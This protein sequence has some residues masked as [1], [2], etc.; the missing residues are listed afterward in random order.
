MSNL[1]LNMRHKC[2]NEE[3]FT[4]FSYSLKYF[5]MLSIAVFTTVCFYTRYEFYLLNNVL[6]TFL[7]RND[8]LLPVT[9]TTNVKQRK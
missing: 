3:C 8:V 1:T 4:V 2:P 7:V 9:N 5:L 6:N